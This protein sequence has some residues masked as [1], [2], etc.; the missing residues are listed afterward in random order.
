[1]TD[2]RWA[3]PKNKKHQKNFILGYYFTLLLL[4]MKLFLIFYYFNI[5]YLLL[6]LFL[7]FSTLYEAFFNFFITLI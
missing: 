6:L 2:V 1:M 3:N 4:S 5:I 7:Y